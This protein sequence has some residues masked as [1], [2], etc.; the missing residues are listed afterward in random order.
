MALRNRFH[1]K[2]F[3]YISFKN[4]NK[5]KSTLPIP[6]LTYELT[7]LI[8]DTQWT[9]IDLLNLRSKFSFHPRIKQITQPSNQQYFI[10]F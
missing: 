2:K 5:P 1:L 4:Q 9:T 7:N 3:N 6:L 10:T 8:E